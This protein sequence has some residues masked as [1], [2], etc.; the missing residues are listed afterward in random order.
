MSSE[1]H[2]RRIHQDAEARR[3]RERALAELR[4]MLAWICG[5]AALASWGWAAALLF[6]PVVEDWD[7]S[8]RLC[9]RPPALSPPESPSYSDLVEAEEEPE[10]CT[11]NRQER[12][13]DAVAP[14]ALSMPP[15]MGLVFL[16]RPRDRAR[17][18]PDG[19]GRDGEG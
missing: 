11:E 16:T 13:L 17:P 2:L 4:P 5:L 1:E 18:T 7:G 6:V 3:A 14:L 12:L 19:P 15:A 10:Q 8:W 9:S